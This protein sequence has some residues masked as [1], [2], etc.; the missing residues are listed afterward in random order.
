MHQ[1]VDHQNRISGASSLDRTPTPCRVPREPDSGNSF[2]IYPVS[3]EVKLNKTER[4]YLKI[5]RNRS[6]G[7][8]I[9]IQNITLKIG[10]DCRFTVDFV[11]LWN[12]EMRF[13]DVKGGF[14]REDSTIKIKTAARMFPMFK[15]VVAQKTKSGWTETVID[16]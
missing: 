11:Y 15:F 3:E 6:L 4:E 16:Q 13:V 14:V 10:N 8:W 2:E 5:I 7:Q 9:G 1:V 12:G